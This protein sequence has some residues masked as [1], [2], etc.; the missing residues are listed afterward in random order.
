M[1]SRSV[2]MFDF[3]QCESRLAFLI[4]TY[5]TGARLCMSSATFFALQF[6]SSLDSFFFQLVAEVRFFFSFF[7]LMLM[8][9]CNEIIFEI[10]VACVA[11]SEMMMD[12]LF[13]AV[14]KQSSHCYTQFT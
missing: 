8:F 9:S 11:T 5:S 7:S 14:K 3:I 6:F 12:L 1:R 13:A 10:K 4:T 2:L